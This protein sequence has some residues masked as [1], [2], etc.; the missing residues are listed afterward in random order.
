MH[1]D[2]GGE[3]VKLELIVLSTFFSFFS[4][5]LYAAARYK[6]TLSLHWQLAFGNSANDPHWVY[7]ES[8]LA[9]PFS[10]VFKRCIS[11]SAGDRLYNIIFRCHPFINRVGVISAG[12]I[13]TCSRDYDAAGGLVNDLG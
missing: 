13:I 12:G 10:K 4:F 11:S 8:S 7:N 5:F 9:Y 2:R 3:G 1:R 6:S